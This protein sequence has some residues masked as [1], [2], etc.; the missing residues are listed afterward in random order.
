MKILVTGATGLL[1]NNLVRQLHARGHTVTGLVRSEEKARRLLGDLDVD[2]VVGDVREPEGFASA[3][4]G[5]DAVFH[6][7]AYFRDYFQPGDHREALATTN[8]D[9]TLSLIRLA[10]ERR[11]GRFVH[12]GSSGTVGREPDG[13][14]SDEDSPPPALAA[15][16]LYVK[17]KIEAATAIRRYTPRHGMAV[18]E[19]LPGWMWGPGDAGPTSAGR[20]ALDLLARRL[21]GVPPG[22]MEVVDAR[23]VAAAMIT[24]AER[25]AHGARYLVAGRPMTL[26]EIFA[27]PGAPVTPA[28]R[29]GRGCAAP[30]RAARE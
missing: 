5:R 30:A 9:A 11:V 16:N 24:A 14:P 29:S 8:V 13:S 25:A 1:G 3:L 23:D 4:E 27:A 10:D 12:T 28:R 22:G 26:R 20:L 2:W 18:V 7:A 19:I 21:P 6:T 15:E 17:S